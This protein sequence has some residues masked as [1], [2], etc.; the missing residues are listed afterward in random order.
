MLNVGCRFFE[1]HFHFVSLFFIFYFLYFEFMG[2]AEG[3]Y[4]IFIIDTIG[5]IAH[6]D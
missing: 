5:R 1:L 2:L 3:R 6:N 4:I